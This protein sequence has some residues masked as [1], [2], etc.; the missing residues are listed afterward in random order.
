MHS[1]QTLPNDIFKDDQRNARFKHHFLNIVGEE[2]NITI[3]IYFTDQN[4]EHF[5]RYLSFSIKKT[6]VSGLRLCTRF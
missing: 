6:G 5:I 4:I 1:L 2:P 3:C